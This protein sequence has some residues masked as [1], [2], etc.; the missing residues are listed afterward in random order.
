MPD[1]TA[2]HRTKRYFNIHSRD[3]IISH[4][5]NHYPVLPVLFLCLWRPWVGLLC[6]F[7]YSGSLFVVPCLGFLC[8]ELDLA[9]G[10][11]PV[12][13]CCVSWPLRTWRS[14]ALLFHGVVCGCSSSA[15][16]IGCRCCPCS[17]A[18]LDAIS[19]GTDHS[20]GRARLCLLPF[21]QYDSPVGLVMP[22]RPRNSGIPRLLGCCVLQCSHML[23]L[24]LWT[25]GHSFSEALST[26]NSNRHNLFPKS[27]GIARRG[28][29][30]T[31]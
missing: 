5:C 29:A 7:L 9:D 25:F 22:L 1:Y 21:L 13:A 16:P 24:N 19:K 31:K 10:R 14:L 28:T 4:I 11:A 18:G 26:L 20:Q 15:F 12:Q 3:I 17:R 8:L 27:T 6:P 23:M 2:L 30:T